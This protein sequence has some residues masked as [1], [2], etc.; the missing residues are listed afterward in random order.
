MRYRPAPS[1]E[2]ARTGAE[3]PSLFKPPGGAR[4]RGGAGDV[5]EMRMSKSGQ[6]TEQQVERDTRRVRGLSERGW[7]AYEGHDDDA[8]LR[9]CRA[10]SSAPLCARVARAVESSAEVD[11]ALAQLG[12]V[13]KRLERPLTPPALRRLTMRALR[14]A[15]VLEEALWERECEAVG[16]EL[17]FHLALRGGASREPTAYHEAAHFV[18]GEAFGCNMGDVS[19]KPSFEEAS[20]GRAA[21]RPVLLPFVEGADLLAQRVC[22]ASTE[23]YVRMALAGYQAELRLDA[24][25]SREAARSDDACVERVLRDMGPGAMP[26]PLRQVYRALLEEESAQLVATLWDGIHAVAQALL[27]RAYLTGEEAADVLRTVLPDGGFAA[28]LP[29]LRDATSYER[30]GGTL[31]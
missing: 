10:L 12:N 16:R 2:R 21:S 15:G 4:R 9:A 7:R 3:L 14:A 11:E 8:C 26:Q 19:L 30:A 17:S 22:L 25:A 27:E 18:V 23:G 20:F 13:R 29:Y 31:G 5:N 28:A 24:S 1:L 6:L